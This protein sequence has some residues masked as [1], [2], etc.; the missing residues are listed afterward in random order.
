M[1]RCFCRDFFTT[2]TA[3]MWRRTCTK[4]GL[5]LFGG[6]YDLSMVVG[7]F[8]FGDCAIVLKDNSTSVDTINHY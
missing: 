2:A 4:M 3:A 6:G 7:E 1:V 8:L 5:N